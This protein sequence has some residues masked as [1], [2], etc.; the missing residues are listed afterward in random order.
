MIQIFAK[1]STILYTVTLKLCVAM[2]MVLILAVW[3][4]SKKY[5]EKMDETKNQFKTY[6]VIIATTITLLTGQIIWS[7]AKYYYDKRRWKTWLQQQHPGKKRWPPPPPDWENLPG[8]PK[9]P[10]GKPPVMK[11]E[12]QDQAQQQ[13]RGGPK[14]RAASIKSY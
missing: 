5:Y 4:A 1:M 9:P 13:Q 2:I 8:I 11:D 14:A 10:A 3:Y 7:E 6:K 12:V